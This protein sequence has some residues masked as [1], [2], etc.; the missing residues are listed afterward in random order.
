MS[1]VIEENSILNSVKKAMKRKLSLLHDLSEN[2][3]KEI[4]KLINLVKSTDTESK[5]E[6]PD[7]ISDSG[8]VEHFHV[9]SGKSN[10]GGYDVTK[11]ESKM[12]KSHETFMANIDSTLSQNNNEIS[13]SR[14]HTQFCRKNDSVENFHKSFKT[15]WEKHINHLHNYNGNKHLSCFLIS[16]DDILSVLEFTNDDVLLDKTENFRLSYDFELL[17]FMY[18]HCTDIDYVIYFNILRN[19]VEIIKVSNIPVIKEHFLKHN[20]KFCSDN[21]IKICNT[22]GVHVPNINKEQ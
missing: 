16:S 2:D 21:A 20:Y 11:E 6:F 10:R 7:F 18:K 15:C 3:Y 22:Y 5:T 17:D 13:F 4:D 1:K 19:Y 8:F 14:H 12:L 9:T